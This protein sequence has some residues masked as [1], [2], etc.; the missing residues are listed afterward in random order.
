MHHPQ[1]YHRRYKVSL[2]AH[3][4]FIV[5]QVFN[6]AMMAV[7]SWEGRWH[8]THFHTP[9]RLPRWPQ[10]WGCAC[11]HIRLETTETLI[12]AP[13][14]A[15]SFC[16]Y[17]VFILTWYARS[18]CL[19]ILWWTLSILPFCHSA[20]RPTILTTTGFIKGSRGDSDD[21]EAAIVV[22]IKSMVTSF[23]GLLK[24][25]DDYYTSAGLPN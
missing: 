9:E 13:L 18:L 8:C 22:Q 17:S 1:H 20:I 10:M 5:R 14:P 19:L 7:P 4:G 2:A 12:S 25:A 3:H 11:H 6:V 15:R 21:D 24:N 23:A 16:I